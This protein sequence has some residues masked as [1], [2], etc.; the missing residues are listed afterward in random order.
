[1][2]RGAGRGIVLQ[3]VASTQQQV[4]KIY[5][6]AFGQGSIVVLDAAFYVLV[7]L[8]A[9]FGTRNR[10]ANVAHARAFKRL[11]LG[12][13]LNNG[14]AF[15]FGYKC[16]D[17]A[18]NLAAQ[19]VKGA[20]N[21]PAA[22]RAHPALHLL[23][24][25]FSKSKRQNLLR[26]RIAAGD[27]VLYARRQRF[28]FARARASNNNKGAFGCFGGLELGKVELFHSFTIKQ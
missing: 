26:R 19:G 1:L 21:W 10:Q 12:D 5:K 25:F 7:F 14:Q 8:T 17:P 18:Q 16:R 23:G 4:I 9:V 15:W 20:N 28:G 24:R 3:K 6:T 13:M 2:L 27:N 11:W 22:K